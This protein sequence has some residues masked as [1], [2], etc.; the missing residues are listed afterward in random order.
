MPH[1]VM[2]ASHAVA[3]PACPMHLDC[4]PDLLW[5]MGSPLHRVESKA[6][7]LQGDQAT[8]GVW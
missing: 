8:P 2:L 1:Q 5:E 4:A 6:Q 3:T 7:L